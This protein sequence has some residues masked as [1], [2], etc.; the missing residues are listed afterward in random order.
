MHPTQCAME[1]RPV[2]C[3]KVWSQQ[4][5]ETLWS[6]PSMSVWSTIVTERLCHIMSWRK[7]HNLPP[8]TL[9]LEFQIGS[10]EAL[11]LVTPLVL[12]DALWL[13]IVLFFFSLLQ[14]PLWILIMLFFGARLWNLQKPHS[15]E[16]RDTLF[17]YRWVNNEFNASL[18]LK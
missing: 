2:H 5:L 15:R 12:Q 6:L 14:D 1:V 7:R 17:N 13:L 16:Q 18:V 3:I 11:D 8:Q 4:V 9:M 10:H